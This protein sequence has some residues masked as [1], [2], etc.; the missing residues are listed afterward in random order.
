[1]LAS[2]CHTSRLLSGTLGIMIIEKS[3]LESRGWPSM[4]VDN[5]WC[6]WIEG[7]KAYVAMPNQGCLVY[8]MEA[9]GG[10]DPD[11]WG[12]LSPCSPSGSI[13]LPMKPAPSCR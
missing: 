3:I 7:I 9:G 8:Q 5:R 4:G 2:Y 12:A 13:C 6:V 1:M 11:R 10:S